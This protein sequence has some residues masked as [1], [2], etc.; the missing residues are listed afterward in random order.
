MLPQRFDVLHDAVSH[1]AV[2]TF[3]DL[4]HLAFL[5]HAL[6]KR[7]LPSL[8]L[9]PSTSRGSLPVA[10]QDQLLGHNESVEASHEAVTADLFTLELRRVTDQPSRR[11]DDH[12]SKIIG[13]I[14]ADIEAT[15]ASPPSP[16]TARFEDQRRECLNRNDSRSWHIYVM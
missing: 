13:W 14:A 10:V 5:G 4:D 15:A 16:D 3:G 9:R 11:R 12:R 6:S 1:F 7:T 8:D 2:D